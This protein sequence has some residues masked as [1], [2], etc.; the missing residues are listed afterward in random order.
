MS[1]GEP[2]LPTL[3]APAEAAERL[4][5]SGD[6][7][8]RRDKRYR[9]IWSAAVSAL[10]GKGTMVL[11]SVIT[12]PLTVRYLGAE[13]YGLWITISST[14]TMFFVFDIGIA[15]TLT[16]LISEAYASNDR[17]RAAASFATAFWMILG[18]AACLGILGWL[19]WPQFHWA[20]IFHVRTEVLGR[21]TSH[22]VAAA[23]IVFLIALPTGLAA[24]VLGGYQELHAANLFATGGSVLSL[25]VVLAVVYV[26]G[27]LTMLV[28]GF[29][30]SSV[31]ASAASLLWICLYHKP[32][33]MPLP[34]WVKPELIGRIFQSGTQF[35]AIQLA[36]LVVFSSDN[37]IIA[38]YLSPADVTPYAV[39]WRLVSYI[40]AVQAIILPALWPA[41]SE[42]FAKRHL[43]WIRCTYSRVRRL[44]IAILTVGGAVML[45]AGRDIIRLWAG[46]AAVPSSLLLWLMVGW[47]VIL[48]FTMNQS[49]LM[50]ATYRV[51]SQALFSSLMA[52]ANLVLSIL[53]VKTAG[54]VG[55]LLAT[56]VSYLI[57]IVPMA[58]WE[59]SRIL[60]GNSFPRQDSQM[61]P[62]NE[63]NESM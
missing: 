49:V 4:S 51:G 19:V 52:V 61:S 10:L 37:L 9:R 47:I 44:T 26:H 45:V 62:I 28:A 56:I 60:R 39:T 20:S 48:A 5:A 29:A 54:V 43:A 18:I 3:D 33:M 59:V 17:E 58:A 63:A 24:K 50:G 35:F 2:V 30:G 16:N 38:H 55:V 13:S 41:Y 36:G 12:V 25:L 31:A 46:P 23:F 40:T 27:S 57:F 7:G 32:W 53:W 15:N 11:V 42:A 22:A 1:T 14:V 34:R 21:E 6:S 8:P